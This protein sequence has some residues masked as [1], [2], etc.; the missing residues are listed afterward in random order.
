MRAIAQTDQVVELSKK[1]WQPLQ[2]A[3]AQ[4]QFR[5]QNLN[6]QSDKLFVLW[7]YLAGL[8]KPPCHRQ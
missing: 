1:E 5:L 2:Y 6:I 4:H 7:N 3:I 8:E